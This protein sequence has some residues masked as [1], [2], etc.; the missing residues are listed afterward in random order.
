[1][2]EK[3]NYPKPNVLTGQLIRE[4]A[5]SAIDVS[6]GLLADLEHI[7]RASG[8]GAVLNLENIP[9]SDVMKSNLEP[10]QALEMALTAGDD[11][12][13]I[14]TAS[15]TNK[16]GLETAMTHADIEYSCIGQLN[17]GNDINL[18]LNGKP[19]I[20]TQVGYQHFSENS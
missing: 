19:F 6:D 17:K 2:L 5:T 18:S 14:F 7:C 20:L 8:L 10:K 15:A 9:L 3:L 13:L 1:A 16:V 11:Y 4:Y 12:Q